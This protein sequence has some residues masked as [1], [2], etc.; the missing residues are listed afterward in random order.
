MMGYSACEAVG[1]P[2][3]LLYRAEDR[4]R[5]QIELLQASTVGAF[6]EEVFRLKKDGTL[7]AAH[8]GQ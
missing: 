7:I 6:E 2:L 3:L 4:A 8:V 5:P 1:Q